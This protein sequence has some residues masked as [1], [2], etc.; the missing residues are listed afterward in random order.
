MQAFAKIVVS[1]F[2]DVILLFCDCYFSTVEQE[3]EYFLIALSNSYLLFT[4]YIR[5]WVRSKKYLILLFM[6]F[7]LFFGTGVI[8]KKGLST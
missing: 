2:I 8:K 6:F 4:H 5:K 1:T 7:L 3:F